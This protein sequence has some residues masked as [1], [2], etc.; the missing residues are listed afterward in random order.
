[1]D[2]E[3]EVKKQMLA[4]WISQRDNLTILIEAL[5]RELG[6]EVEPATGTLGIRGGTPTVIVGPPKIKPGEF[7]GQSQTEA[8]A[9]YLRRLG[10]AAQIDQILEALK[11]GGVKFSG[12]A[13][14][15]NLY[16]VL[17]RGTRRFVLVSPGTFGLIEFYPDRPRPEKKQRGKRGRPPK[18]ARESQKDAG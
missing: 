1:M 12:A 7:F 15:G 5:Q 8:A 17:V 11:S 18:S 4:K 6:E 13:P 14:K 3:H 10:H 9:T 2:D 16:T